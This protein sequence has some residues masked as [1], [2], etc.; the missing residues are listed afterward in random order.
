MKRVI[1]SLVVVV[2]LLVGSFVRPSGA[3]EPK[4]EMP[5]MPA[6]EKEHTW[7]TQLAGEWESE[8]ECMMEPGKPP[9]KAKGSETA[10]AVG[11]FWVLS[12]IRMKMM[13]NEVT[14]ILTLG[15]DPE[16]KR[17]V[18][19]WVDSMGSF[20]WRYTGSLDAAGKVLTLDTEGPNMMKPGTTAK[21]KE[22]VELKDK[23]TKVF[24]SSMQMEDGTWVKFMTSTSRRKK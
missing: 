14:G 19:T 23:D 16:K 24:S 13:E 22:V 21:F 4:V 20:M 17:F 12:E 8:A 15:Y 7:V 5:K 6:P 9:V 1:A 3:A 18:G 10:R 2:L 11:G